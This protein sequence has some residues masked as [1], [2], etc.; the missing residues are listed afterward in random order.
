[1]ERRRQV[2]A[3]RDNVPRRKKTTTETGK[4]TGEALAAADR[5]A[6]LAL[7]GDLPER[8]APITCSRMGVEERPGYT[9]E[10]LVLDVGGLER[11]PAYFTRPTAAVGR[12]PLV[13]YHHAHGND[14]ALGKDE[15]LRGRKELPSGPYVED[16][17][18]AGYSVLAVDHWGFGERRGRSESAL[19]KEH[20]WKGRVLFG[21]M[22]F[23]A[24]RAFDYA[25]TRPDVD[26][27]RVAVLGMSMGSTLSWWSAALEERLGVVVDICCLTDF[28]ALLDRGG[29]DGHGIYYYVP[30][31]LKRFTTARIQALICPRPHLALA[32]I[33]DPLTPPEGLDRIDREMKQLY[34]LAGAAGA[35]QLHRHD[36]GHLETRAMRKQALDFL[37]EHLG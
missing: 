19:F 9:L 26:P 2:A 3:W 16:L 10:H 29:L 17:T 8:G 32:G 18:A 33:H 28:H 21:L 23:D 24:L 4:P 13:L 27:G 25:I 11:V 31:L 7:L 14:F 22:V 5:G 36:C 12:R 35:W 6:L 30:G 34:S 37:R 1:M 15:L 20:L